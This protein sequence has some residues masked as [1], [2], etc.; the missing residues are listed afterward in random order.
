M[1]WRLPGTLQQRPC[2]SSDASCDFSLAR[3]QPE[4]AI[5]RA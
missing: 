5:I 1:C 2:L 3:A 4:S